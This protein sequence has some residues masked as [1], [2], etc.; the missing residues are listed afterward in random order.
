AEQMAGMLYDSLYDKLLNLSDT[1]E[2]WPAH[3]KGS[4]CGRNISDETSSTIGRQRLYNYALRPMTKEEFV[5]MMTAELAEA[6]AYFSKDAE[7]NRVG[8]RSLAGLPRPTALSPAEVKKLAGCGATILDVRANTEF[9]AGH[10]PGALNIGL[11]GP[12]DSWAGQLLKF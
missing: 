6:P 2:V 12:F 1:V 7:I 9:G 8:A 11:G 3:G 10:V 5:K 4:L